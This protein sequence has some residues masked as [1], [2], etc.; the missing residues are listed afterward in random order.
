MGNSK[1][2]I[3]KIFKDSGYYFELFINEE[4]IMMSELY[5]SKDACENGIAMMKANAEQAEID[6]QTERVILFTRQQGKSLR[7]SLDRVSHFLRHYPNTSPYQKR[8]EPTS[9][10]LIRRQETKRVCLPV[11]Y[12]QHIEYITPSTTSQQLRADF[13]RLTPI[14]RTF[15]E[16]TSLRSK[17]CSYPDTMMV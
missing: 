6:D 5:T 4:R 17:G 9:S 10:K 7:L 13:L 1:F 14:C 16:Q 8:L 12:Q 11:L 2:I 3:K 15:H